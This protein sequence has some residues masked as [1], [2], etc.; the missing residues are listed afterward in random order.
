MFNP[1]FW[2]VTQPLGKNNPIAGFVHILPN[3]TLYLTQHFLECRIL[4]LYNVTNSFRSPRNAGHPRRTNVQ[5]DRIMRRISVESRFNTAAGI[6]HQFSDEQGKDL[7]WHS[8]SIFLEN[9][10]WKHTLQLPNLSSAEKNQK[11]RLNIYWGAFYVER[12]ETGPNCK[13]WKQITY[14]G[15]KGNILFV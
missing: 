14:L 8:V 11:A 5:E 1:T 9:L 12:G 2:A 6:A 15:L 3:T 10:D 7:S 4:H 13:C